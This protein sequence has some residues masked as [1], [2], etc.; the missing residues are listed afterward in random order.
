MTVYKCKVAGP[1]IAFE[2][3]RNGL[4]D[5]KEGID[6]ASAQRWKEKRRKSKEKQ[7]E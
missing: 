6:K 2:E 3:K 7:Q 4:A 5:V 1:A